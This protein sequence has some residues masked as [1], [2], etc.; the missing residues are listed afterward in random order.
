MRQ[1]TYISTTTNRAQTLAHNLSEILFFKKPKLKTPQRALAWSVFLS[2]VFL[3]IATSLTAQTPYSCGA[4]AELAQQ[5]YWFFGTK[6]GLDFGT[7]GTGPISSGLSP[8]NPLS[9]EGTVVA[10]NSSG[11]LQFFAG[12][13]TV[14]NSTGV[15][16]ANGTGLTGSTSATQGAVAF[17][18]PGYPKNYFLVTNLC[19][20]ALNVPNGNLYY[21]RI[22]M[23][24]NGGLGAVTTKNTLLGTANTA[25]EALAAVPNH[26][27]TKAWVLTATNG[28]NR[29]LAYEF[30]GDGPTGVVKTST[31][32]SNNG[33]WFGTLRFSADMSK[34]VQL[35]NNNGETSWG[36]TQIRLLDFN[37]QTG[38][39]TENWTM[40]IPSTTIGAGYGADFSPNGNYIYVSCI[41]SGDLYQYSLASNTGAGVLASGVQLATTGSLGNIR[42]AP[43]GKM[44]VANLN[45]NTISVINSPNTAGVGADFVLNGLTLATGQESEWGL[46]EMVQGCTVAL[47]DTDTDG[48]PDVDDL[49]DDNDGILDTAECI[50]SNN[51]LTNGTFTGSGTGWT[52]GGN[53]IYQGAGNM[54]IYAENDNNDKLSQTFS[55]PTFN[56]ST[57]TVPV[58][59]DIQASGPGPITFYAKI[60]VVINNT[61]VAT[62]TNPTTS[63]VATVVPSNGATTSIANFDIGGTT[64]PFT[65]IT[66]NVP[67]SLFTNSNT[68]SFSF[69]STSD[70]FAIDNVFIP[71]VITSCDT[72]NDGIPNQLDLD[73]DGD[74]C[75]DAIEG[76][77][78]FTT[79]NLVT[80]T[81]AGGN[82]G[83]GYTGTSTS[84]VTQNLGN[85]VGSTV[86]A[87]GVPTVAVTG[88]TIGYSQNGS[89]NACTDTDTD[90]I[91]D[92][93]DLDDDNDGILDTA[94]N[95]TLPSVTLAST[96][97]STS[98]NYAVVD[99]VVENNTKGGTVKI[100]TA[101]VS[102]A[103]EVFE[104][105]IRSIATGNCS[106][107]PAQ[108]S[109]V[110]DITFSKSVTNAV[111]MTYGLEHINE[112]QDFEILAPY[113]GTPEFKILNSTLGATLIKLSD[114]K[115][116]LK[117][118]ASCGIY[119][120]CSSSLTFQITGAFY[121]KIRLSGDDPV[122][123]SSCRASK[124][125]LDDASTNECNADIDGDGIP[126]HL[127]LDSDGD[128]C[129]DAI[130]GGAAFTP[131]NTTATGA[132]SG[133]VS[134]A[135]ATLGVPVSAGTGQSIGDS[136]NSSINACLDTDTDGIPDLDDLDDDNDG[137]LDITES[138]CFSTPTS[139]YLFG[140]TYWNSISWTGG[141]VMQPL[142]GNVNAVVIPTG[143]IDG[144][145]IAGYSTFAPTGI[146]SNTFYNNPVTFTL[147]TKFPLK[148]SG[149]AIVNDYAV[150]ADGIKVADIKLYSN[151]TFLGTERFSNI[152]SNATSSFYPF[153]TIYE[154]VTKI[155]VIVYEG[156]ATANTPNNE[157]QV[158]EMGL[159]SSTMDSYCTDLDTDGD[160]TPNRL[161]LDSDGDGCPDAVEAGTTA[162]TTSGVAAANKLTASVIPAPYG[163]NGFANGLE[164]VT[165][166]GTYK[167]TYS[168]NDA[169]NALVKGCTDTDTDG[170]PDVDD[171]DDDNDGIL[172]SVECPA[173]LNLT[174]LGMFGYAHNA[175]GTSLIMDNKTGALATNI[176]PYFGSFVNETLGAGVTTTVINT[177]LRLIGVDKLTLT[178]AIAADDY[179]EWAF[180]STTTPTVLTGISQGT[181]DNTSSWKVTYMVSKN[182][183]AFVPLVE[184]KVMVGVVNGYQLLST[185][186]LNYYFTPGNN[187]RIRAYYYGFTG[188]T[189]WLDDSNFSVATTSM[190]DINGDDFINSDDTV[191]D[192]DGDGIPNTLDLDSDGDGCS[193][194]IEGGAAFTAANLSGNGALSGAVSNAAATLGVPTSAG[195]GQTIGSS[196]NAG[197]KDA[198]CPP[199]CVAG[200]T[201]PNLSATSISNVCPATTVNLTSITASNTPANT[202]LTWHSG[203]PATTANKIT[204]T[205][206]AA[207]TYYAAF[208][209]A[210]NNCYSGTSG[211]G[212]TAVTVTITI[213]CPTITNTTGN[214]VNPS[215]CGTATGSVKI[216]GLTANASG[217]TVNY[218][219]N[220]TAATALTNQTA[221]ASG[222]IMITGLTAGAYTN[223]KISSTACPAGS[224]ALSATLT[225]PTG[226]SAPTGLAGVPSSGIC[227][228]TSVALSATGTTGATYTWTVSPTGATLAS[229][230]GTVSGT[231]AS[232]TFN[233]TVAGTYTISLTQTI[234][235]CTSAA[236]TTTITVNATP[237]TVVP[238]AT[239]KSNVCPATTV[240]LTTLQPAAV[241]GVTYEWHT[242]ASNPTSGTLVATPAAAASGTYYLYGKSASGCYSAASSA[243]TATVNACIP[244][245]PVDPGIVSGSAASIKTGNTASFT[246]TGAT[247][248]TTTW[249]IFPSNGVSPNTGTGTSTGL[250]TFNI[251]GEY[252]VLF[253]TKNSNTPVGCSEPSFA[254][255]TG[256]FTV[257]APLSPC[258][259]PSASS[260][261]VSPASAAISEGATASFTMSGGTPNSS[262]QWVIIPST[263][264]S[265][266]SGT[267]TSTG[268]VTFATKGLYTAVFSIVNLG[269]GSCA[270]VQQSSS[271]PIAVGLSPCSPP[272]SILVNS[273][274]AN[275]AS[276]VGQSVTFTATGGIPGVRTWT[277]TPAT[278]ASPSSGTGSTATITFTAGGIYSVVFT[279][280][281]S[282]IPLGCTQP[283]N[284]SASIIH[285]VSGDT[286][287]DGV[288]DAQEA[289]DGTNPNDGCSYNAASQVLASTSAAWKALD[290][291]NDG[292]PNGT[293]SQPKNPCVPNANSLAC[294]T[295]D[296]DGDGVTNGQEA[297]DGTNPSN[298]C[299]YNVASQVPAN[300]SA[301]WKASDCDNDGNTN[302]TD[303]NPLVPVAT[304]DMLTAPQGVTSTVNVLTNDDFLPGAG[305]S[306]TV[307][308]GGTATGTATF[309]PL[310][311]MLSYVPAPGETGLVTLR[312][313]VCNTVPNP[314]VCAEATVSITISATNAKL[315]LKV[316]LQGALLPTSSSGGPIMTGIMRDDLRT[317]SPSQIPNLEPYTGL[318][319][320]RFTHVGGGGETMGAGVLS[321]AGNDA[322]VDWVFVELRDKNNPATILKTRSALVQRDGDVVESTDGISPLTFTG[323]VG[324]SYYV[325]VKHRNHLG[326]MTAGAI[327]MT[328]TGTLV[329]FTT[330][331]AAQTYHL[332]GYDGFEQVD[333]NGK[334]ALWAGNTNAD[335]KVKYVG[336]GNDQIPVFGQAVNYVTNTTQQYNFDFATPVYLSGDINMDAKV[337]YRGPNNDTSF[338]FFN[339]ITKYALL[340]T[341]ALYNYD[342]FIEQLP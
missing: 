86:N 301:A 118:G 230:A 76:G 233:S 287:G 110:M 297:I 133:S 128:G 149:F 291:D 85:T 242:V 222:C 195:T 308:S 83:A 124:I 183:N 278:G 42:R 192:T 268:S 254:T 189:L 341:G 24:Q 204:G 51:L 208:F 62:I 176:N 184:D 309:N 181:H 319:N 325:S 148:A 3:S 32:S 108:D 209:D 70:D 121:T 37:A 75:S 238:T 79:A 194:A 109:G 274:T 163:T 111:F 290:C 221:D 123:N 143:Y 69:Y 256:Q 36:P 249:A 5:R 91:P 48:I 279:S 47:T 200:A 226:P 203:T 71:A 155:E 248:G 87:L 267:G 332:P 164:T 229:V 152:I 105:P 15:A 197:V 84:P 298:G 167:G 172:D 215:A 241:S 60:D 45:K 191:C 246:L 88:Q 196:Q 270:P 19:S 153:S 140:P 95:C 280:K 234:S 2:F 12:P 31:L 6:V 316:L 122:A 284:T 112:Y 289:I 220:G 82:S 120:N 299:S 182:G 198:N 137:I 104:T 154:N 236:A 171:L 52:F 330:M 338:I 244:C 232:N 30:D 311:G 103:T 146:L 10:T 262:V 213:C 294:P 303:P 305:T 175:G 67:S 295:G 218:D 340:N 145:L 132:L 314:D 22:D 40:T 55:A 63:N 106:T 90:G 257:E 331:T 334:M 66:V 272:T 53:W 129:F 21:H 161:D 317:A 27:G 315:N 96:Y 302:G 187:Y 251:A 94:E 306:L 44:Y 9:L 64:G 219:K 304:N 337:K 324:E 151:N 210:T 276:N 18:R 329:D 25:S 265:P 39:L 107:N 158:S 243:V 258:A 115:Y 116:R 28:T 263:G 202:T 49:D 227:V 74:G 72:D 117:S 89:I 46:P 264:V 179:S 239:S 102:G 65:P 119:A 41:G 216:C 323:A 93:D 260:V 292:T 162:I 58:S 273:S 43:N 247:A 130:E 50:V 81:M 141:T 320:S 318:A 142:T 77:A 134:S 185:P 336:V 277:V 205:A 11:V 7:T 59:F 100:S 168:Y 255:A 212:T 269:D 126:N 144:N 293:D 177:A 186:T 327:A 159:Y 321:A 253:S 1:F 207:G 56:T 98:G 252:Q 266:S 97:S 54:Y 231:T 296:T 73:S 166:N 283:V 29:I 288:S 99:G 339:V 250:V 13:T 23:T 113:S 17:Q 188:S 8:A 61:V 78:A 38:Q 190:T 271:A 259:K 223:I 125:G 170:I 35:S 68:I 240:D 328:A 26:D 217:Y 114:T 225:D 326:A 342:L 307:I 135:A 139:G 101:R 14:Y 335:K 174:A 138:Q 193:D 131:A 237:S 156:N 333:V 80:S 178:D 169:T 92:I 313:R 147:N 180:S 322:I 34:V 136:Q 286:D 33:L 214:N 206:V 228:G 16:M 160:G 312:Y 310:T 57:S 20:V 4:A 281:N 285:N 275:Q 300:T 235:G 282:T 224:N 199:P 157:M 245:T 165:D 150:L 261:A 211:S 173:V 127:D 201:A